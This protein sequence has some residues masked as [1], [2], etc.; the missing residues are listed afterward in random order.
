MSLP[1]RNTSI[2]VRYYQRQRRGLGDK[3]LD[4]F[5]RTMARI[6]EAP[7]RLKIARAPNIR[8]ITFYSRSFP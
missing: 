8:S 2:G 4:D 7:W 6:C 1:K 3:Y 5:D